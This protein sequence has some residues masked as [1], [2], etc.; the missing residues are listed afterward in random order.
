MRMTFLCLMVTMGLV[1]GCQQDEFGNQPVGSTEPLAGE[2][3]LAGQRVHNA[4][5]L[6]SLPAEVQTAFRRDFPDAS[7]SE[8]Q[9]LDVATGPQVYRIAYLRQGVANRVTYDR[10]GQLVAPPMPT[11]P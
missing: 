6:S 4:E 10:S 7:V 11:A 3:E 8:V 5:K 9:R 2:P 1:A